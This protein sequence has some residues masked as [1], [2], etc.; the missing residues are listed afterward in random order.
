[1]DAQD[2]DKWRK[3]VAELTETTKPFFTDHHA[4]IAQAIFDALFVLADFAER[5]GTKADIVRTKLLGDVGRHI[6]Q[7]ESDIDHLHIW[8]TSEESIR[9][10]ESVLDGQPLTIA[11]VAI[12][13]FSGMRAP[14]M[15]KHI[16]SYDAWGAEQG[17]DEALL[18]ED[19]YCLQGVV[20]AML[21]AL[22]EE[23]GADLVR[24][25]ED[26]TTVIALASTAVRR[27]LAEG[28]RFQDMP[29]FRHP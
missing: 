22:G 16:F 25:R 28:T 21:T 24:A 5:Y 2:F 18:Y 27:R 9:G 15:S 20:S 29:S 12:P 26:R 14:E 4:T 8:L 1:M 17:V 13:Q 23:I 3:Q 10:I 19:W 6:A 11:Q 7:C